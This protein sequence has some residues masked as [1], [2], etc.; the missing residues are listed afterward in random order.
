MD[1]LSALIHA[2]VISESVISNF[3]T[4]LKMN[5]EIDDVFSV[6]F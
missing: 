4:T 1:E 6:V 5:M 2:G 3:M